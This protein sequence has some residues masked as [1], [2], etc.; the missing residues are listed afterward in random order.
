MNYL[1]GKTFIPEQRTDKSNF[2]SDDCMSS[3][4][5]TNPSGESS[6]SKNLFFACSICKSAL[7]PES[8]CAICKRTLVRRC[9][10]CAK[11]C[12][13]P[14]HESCKMLMYYRN[15]IVHKHQIDV[16]K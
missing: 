10:N 12:E 7:I 13:M 11:T 4:V 9:T 16:E 3:H 2:P 14:D 6:L 8:L 1:R 5:L 15:E